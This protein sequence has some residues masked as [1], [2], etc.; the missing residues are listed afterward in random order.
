VLIGRGWGDGGSWYLLLR[1]GSPGGG[2]GPE[3]IAYVSV[4]VVRIIIFQ[5]HKLSLTDQSHIT[6]PLRFSLSN[7][8]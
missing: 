5:L 8:V 1:P 2:L 7:L 3:Y 6:L 4:I